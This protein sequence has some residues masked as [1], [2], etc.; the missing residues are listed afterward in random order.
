MENTR[1]KNDADGSLSRAFYDVYGRMPESDPNATGYLPNGEPTYI[2]VL[3]QTAEEVDKD[4][5]D[6]ASDDL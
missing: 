4:L 3:D 2:Q 6:L 1:L 5:S